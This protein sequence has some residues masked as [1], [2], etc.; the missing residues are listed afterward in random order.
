MTIELLGTGTSQ[1][2]PVIGCNCAVCTSGD[3]RDKRLRCSVW[4]KT[5]STSLVIDAGPD[6]RTQ[7]LRSKVQ[8]LDALLITHE[9]NDHIIGMDD[10]RPFN[11][12]QK[13]DMPVFATPEVQSQLKQRFD[14]AFAE[15]PYPGAPRLKLRSINSKD[16]FKVNEIEIQ[17][18]EVLHGN[19]PVLG[20]RIGDFTYITDANSIEE[21]ERKKIR[22]TKHL[23][24]N[25][26]H[27]KEHYSHF[28]L[29]Q[30]LEVIKDLEPENAYLTHI[31]HLMGKTEVINQELPDNVQLAYDGIQIIL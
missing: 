8:K 1:G 13:E 23:V 19:M 16:T 7:M 6:F 12:K 28:N 18:I 27:H 3:D 22:G 21:N 30:A 10:V 14:Y 11:F 5:E 25:A 15:N 4:I 2:V 20:F 9:H 24:I 29:S 31:S 26:L 17:P